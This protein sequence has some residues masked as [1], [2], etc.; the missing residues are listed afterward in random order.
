MH[1]AN[2]STT[3]TPDIGDQAL[4]EDQFRQFVEALPKAEL[5]LHFEGTIFP[6][7]RRALAEKN[8]LALPEYAYET[9]TVGE[10]TNPEQRLTVFLELLE[11]SRQVLV[12][13]DDF[14]TTMVELIRKSALSGTRYAE[15]FFDPQAHTSR[16]VPFAVMMEGLLAGRREGR[17]L[18]GVD[19][20]LIMSFHRYRS[21]E[22]AMEMLELAEPF[23][24]EI[25][26]LGLDDHEG[27]D[28]VSRFIDVFAEGR[29]QGYRLTAHCDVD[30]P[31]AAENMWR[32][33]RELGVERIDHGLN[34]V[35]D[36]A[37]LAHMVVNR[38]PITACPTWS[39]VSEKPSRFTRMQ[40]LHQAGMLV[41]L[42]SDDPGLFE[43]GTIANVMSSYGAVVGL[44]IQG[45][46]EYARASFESAWID[47][48][49]RAI[50]IDEL[51]AYLRDLPTFDR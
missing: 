51:D 9:F 46:A 43:S 15:V 34:A 16:G 24:D 5:H 1:T 22:S 33:I 38:I 31:F 19:V 2:S 35:D 11:A 18:F 41:S 30:Q 23:K 39:G 36:A 27:G 28:W 4:P 6:A 49:T 48:A 26:G 14:R 25:L 37:L 47:D 29:R 32:C 7:E 12:S 44:S 40:I 10:G 3:H 17:E 50:Y 8:N 21:A 20:N 45:L 42:N 13:T